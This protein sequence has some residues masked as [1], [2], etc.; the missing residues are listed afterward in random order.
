MLIAWLPN[1]RMIACHCQRTTVIHEYRATSVAQCTVMREYRPVMHEYC[2]I[3]HECRD[4][5]HGNRAVIH[6]YG[7]L[8]MDNARSQY[9]L[10]N[11]CFFT[12]WHLLLH[13]RPICFIFLLAVTFN[14]FRTPMINPLQDDFDTY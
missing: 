9:T 11:S 6:E 7:L 1:L 3:T 12:L 8:P 5:T 14:M 10:L 2:A 4:V 13:G